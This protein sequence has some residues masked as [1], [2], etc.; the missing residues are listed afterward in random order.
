MT[1]VSAT[2]LL[3]TF[4]MTRVAYGQL[5]NWE[6]N[7]ALPQTWTTGNVGIGTSV[8][9][10]ELHVLDGVSRFGAALN[11]GQFDVSGNLRF[12]GTGKY[13]VAGNTYAFKAPG[14]NS[15]IGLYFN[16]ANNRIEFR[17]GAGT[18]MF[19]T[20]VAGATP[21]NGYFSG[22]LGVGTATPQGKVHSVGSDVLPSFFA[23]AGNADFA[24]ADGEGIQFGNWNNTTLVFT[25]RVRVTNSGRL[26]VGTG[27]PEGII[28]S[29]GSG[30]IPNFYSSGSTADI[31]VADGNNL[32]MG[33]WN[34]STDTFT[35]RLKIDGGGNVGIGTSTP[36]E[37][38]D[39]AGTTRTQIL[40]IV[41]GSDLAEPFDIVN[42]NAPQ[43][44]MVVCISAESTGQLCIANRAYDRTVAGILSGAGGINPGMVMS[45]SGTEADG[46]YPVA[47]SGR[48]YCWVD[49]TYGAVKPGDLL[50]TSE[51]PGHA[52]KASDHAKAQ[53]AIIGKA[54][55]SLERE[56]GLVLVLV[57]LQ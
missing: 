30:N 53:G 8:P 3:T 46:K 47:L 26:G 34:E 39:V 31:A 29:V 54:M 45:K 55:T 49:A 38:L 51:T 1:K 41:G 43:P 33:H 5:G 48:V 18:R 7:G 52:M 12:F 19:S 27:S 23:G 50:T 24:V 2:I 36:Q 16:S 9:A 22:R 32:Q 6:D 17:D 56:K 37:K 35:E 40:E 11:Y 10:V 28:H 25:E 21:G 44:G 13:L 42:I 57:T 15:N 20:D 14:V 4:S